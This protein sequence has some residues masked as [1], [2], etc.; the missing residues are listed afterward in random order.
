MSG[1]WEAGLRRDQ[2]WSQA[3]SMG[4]N[5][6]DGLGPPLNAKIYPGNNQRPRPKPNNNWLG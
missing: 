2:S 6:S 3:N 4:A 1:S 5:I